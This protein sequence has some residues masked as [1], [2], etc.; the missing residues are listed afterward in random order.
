SFKIVIAR[1][2]NLALFRTDE[3]NHQESPLDEIRQ[4]ESKRGD[5]LCQ[6][7]LILFEGDKK[8]RLCKVGGTPHEKLH[9]EK[10]FSATGAARNQGGTSAGQ[11][12]PG[13]LIE[14]GNACRRLDE[15]RTLSFSAGRFHWRHLWS[16]HHYC[17]GMVV[18]SN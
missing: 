4:I 7:L 14:P 15:N 10:R 5:V 17:V 11:S 3:I 12:P 2:L 18:G 6:L 8:T 16:F 13:D 1:L 9:T